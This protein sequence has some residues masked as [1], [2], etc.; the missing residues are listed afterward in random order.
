MQEM[1]ELSDDELAI[2]LWYRDDKGTIRSMING[3]EFG[4]VD[5]EHM[6]VCVVV[7]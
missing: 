2:S 5:V 4:W 1:K 3:R 6:L 7:W